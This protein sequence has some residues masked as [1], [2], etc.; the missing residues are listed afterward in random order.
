MGKNT[1]I[2]AIEL[3]IFGCAYCFIASKIAVLALYHFFISSYAASIITTT[4]SIHI[5]K[6][7]TREKFV[8]KLS[9]YHIQLRT[10]NV[11]KN[12]SGI[13]NVAISDCFNPINNHIIR[14]ISSTD[15]SALD[16]SDA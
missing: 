9:V 6:V 4:V 13:A 5:P 7:S 10:M 2:L 1:I 16:P 3:V 12:D 8:K 15:C 14:K 11:M